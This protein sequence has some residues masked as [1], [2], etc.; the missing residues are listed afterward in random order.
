MPIFH[1]WEKLRVELGN[2]NPN[3]SLQEVLQQSRMFHDNQESNIKNHNKKRK[4]Y[5][6]PTIANIGNIRLQRRGWNGQKIIQV[7]AEESLSKYGLDSDQRPH[8]VLSKNSIPIEHYVGS[9]EKL[10]PEPREWKEI[11]SE[12]IDTYNN[13]SGHVVKISSGKVKHQD[14][15]RCTIILAV[16]NIQQLSLPQDENNWT[17]KL[18]RHDEKKDLDTAKE[19]ENGKNHHFLSSEWQW[20]DKPFSLPKG[21]NKVTIRNIDGIYKIE[22]TIQRTTKIK[23][24]LL[25]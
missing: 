14:A 12:Y 22:F 23:Q 15:G 6:L 24:W 21:R 17:G 2:A 13:D 3:D 7:S 4:I 9:A 19:K 25:A 16:S 11:P 8:T 5:S 18:I 20:F 1:E 10:R